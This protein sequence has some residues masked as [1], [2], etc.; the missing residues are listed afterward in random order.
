MADERIRPP[1]LSIPAQ[2]ASRKYHNQPLV[3]AG[4]RFDSQVE[5]ARYLVL[6]ERQNRGQISGLRPQPRYELQAA[7]RDNQGRMTRAITYVADFEYSDQGGQLV[8]E[9][10]KGG[11]ATQ[12]QVWRIKAKMFKHRYPGIELRVVEA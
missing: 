10:V 3:I 8:A 9:D 5:A 1:V 6:L 7:F 2:P 12:T 11:E 4:E